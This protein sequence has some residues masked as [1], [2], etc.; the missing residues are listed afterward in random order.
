MTDQLKARRKTRAGHRSCV[1]KLLP[2]A[3][4]VVNEFTSEMRDEAMKL[5]TSLAGQLGAMEPLDQEILGLLEEKE[6]TTEEE[7]GD[8]IEKSCCLRS[9]IKTVIER[10][11]ELLKPFTELNKPSVESSPTELSPIA[12]PNKNVRAK[13]PKLEVRKF[14]GKLEE[15]QEFWDSFN[16]A[17]HENDDLS[18]VDKF[19]YLKGLITGSAKA[20]IAGF[21]LTA[22]NYGSAVEL[23]K[24]RYGK[25]TLIRRAHIRE[26]LN[27]QAVYSARD[28][29]RL[30]ALFDIIE[31]HYRGLQAL[32][33]DE[34]SFSDI[35]V[36]S[37][38][39]KIPEAVRLTITR[40][41]AHTEWSTKDLLIA[42]EKEVELREEYQTATTRQNR[43]ED[44]GKK[45]GNGPSTTNSF[46]TKTGEACAFCLGGHLHEE[47]RKV[48]DI[49]ERKKLIL[50]FA[51]CFNCLKKG[52]RARDCKSSV[53]CKKC[54]GKHH[55]A[56]CEERKREESEGEAKVVT[57]GTESATSNLHVR[58]SSRVVLQTAQALAKGR[59]EARIRVLFDS[60]SQKSFVKQET[61]RSLGL[62]PIR[63]EWLAVSTFGKQLTESRLRNVVAVDLFPTGGGR[64]MRVE[65]YVVPEISR[66][67]NEHVEVVKH[68]FPHLQDIW[69]SDVC[70]RGDE[71]EVDLLIGADYL[72]RFQ[73]GCMI[74]GEIDE[75]VAL[76]T[77]LG[78]VL[79]GPLK[80]RP[81]SGEHVVAH[82]SCVTENQKVNEQL[83]KNVQKLWDLETLGITD[84]DEVHEE[85]VDNISFN[86]VRYSVK[87]PWKEGH[88]NLP[89]NYATSLSRL[90][91]QVK[92]LRKEPNLLDEYDAVI[93]EQLNSGVVEKVAQL[94][95]ADKVH[96]LPHLAVV[97]KEAST[98]K[99]RIVYD[100]SARENGKGTSLNDCL[101]VGPSLNPLLFDILVRFREKKVVLIGDI[102]KAF[103][104]IEVAENDRDCLRFLWLANAHDPNSE[105]LVYRFCRVVF[106]LNASPFLLN[107]TLRHH[108]S[109][110]NEEDPEFVRAM[111]ESFYV[112]DLVSGGNNVKEA[113]RLYVNSKKRL[114][115]G[116]FKLRKWKTNNKCLRDQISREENES[117]F[118]N[119][120]NEEPESY[121]KSTLGSRVN[122]KYEKVLG[123]SWDCERD[124]IQFSFQQLVSAADKVKPTKR[125]VLSLLAGLFDPLG[126]ISPVIVCMKLLFQDLCNAKIDWDEELQDEAKR[127][128]E[129]WV[130]ELREAEAITIDRCLYVD[131]TE[132]VHEYQ[133]HGFG[134]ASIK[135]YCAIVYL[136]CQTE[137]RS[138]A[139]M[140]ASK[141][142]VAPLKAL[143]IPRLELMSARLLAQ[144]VHTVKTAL[145]AQVKISKI[146]Y[147][148]DSKTA[149]CWIQNRGEWKQFVRHR[150]NEILRLSSKDDWRHCPG[151]FNPA[152]IG[153]R[154]VGAIRLKED[155]LWWQG[156]QWLSEE[157]D[158]WPIATCG[159][160]TFD[161]RAEE[162]SATT[163]IVETRELP[164]IANVISLSKYSSLLRLIRISAWVQRFARNCR[165]DGKHDACRES[166]LTRI[167]L[168][169]AEEEW[170]K[171]AQVCLRKQENFKQLESKFDLRE[172]EG[173]LRCVGRL[174]NADLAP[175]ARA[176]VI[177]PND[178]ELTK[179]II[180]ECHERVHHCGT[181]ATLTELRTKYW[182]P[183]G[184]QTVK[185]I[186]NSCVTCK[187]LQGPAY[188]A[189]KVAPLPEFRVR[190]VPAFS[191]VGIDFAGPLY[192]KASEGVQGKYT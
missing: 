154:G 45:R 107:A 67:Q 106:G 74:S 27:V 105:V 35:V 144:L 29:S 161:S 177:L 91:G 134:D 82:V 101:H 129:G 175:E 44:H 5:R 25:D 130:E 143:T 189:P 1:A 139:R 52:H 136:V 99:L 191:K 109:K 123:L 84:S 167:E 171:A 78:W 24:K 93:K 48:T 12:K 92:K 183:K 88:D 28:S 85:F 34:S 117:K 87:L 15:W 83:D 142:R 71:L 124:K 69:F 162:K 164:S 178:H 46:L 151:E 76:E 138:Y 160:E 17:I 32:G 186:V 103:L 13:L 70:R 73:T 147:W 14:N 8:E 188:N 152:D 114:A 174:T 141:S 145:Q 135:A 149:L 137:R 155:T 112:D 75:P 102:E 80:G 68:D 60:A 42:L 187:R 111:I 180:L 65:A 59:G 179:M 97:R 26:L 159:T 6:S 190:E 90:K 146:T 56:I 125:N 86:G 81:G 140:I 169:R 38:L 172:V 40:G 49:N 4:T 66:I 51:R 16:S 64:A 58:T 31:T 11:E 10:L 39:E 165:T 9:E 120:P 21:A 96:Y 23:L 63:K 98:T 166:N 95:Q 108:V 104:N 54:K 156:P 131:P 47:C 158:K 37:L 36:P 115:E 184:R 3:K 30:R 132:N 110:Y 185:K 128:W 7:M 119:T 176:P 133:I 173:V 33:V 77:S 181:R 41:K 22:V 192:V 163:M 113:H 62:D 122:P 168:V 148:L 50:K 182:V 18:D 118:Q 157:E 72:W 116:G 20:A 126:I 121:A 53:N 153:S 89:R 2:E 19:T 150:V 79:S 100:A 127:K 170:I 55:T 57:S 43:E 61:V 94:E